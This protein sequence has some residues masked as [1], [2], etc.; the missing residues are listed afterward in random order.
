MLRISFSLKDA[1][2]QQYPGGAGGPEVCI[3]VF[4]AHGLFFPRTMT[5]R[6]TKC[7]DGPFQTLRLVSLLRPQLNPM[8]R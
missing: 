3:I 6:A 8:Q 1:F 5:A 4:I 2:W 7:L